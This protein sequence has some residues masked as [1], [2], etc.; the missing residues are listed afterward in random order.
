MGLM[1]V[2]LVGGLEGGDDGEI[3]GWVWRRR[4]RRD[5]LSSS[6]SLLALSLC[7]RVCAWAL[8]HS[9]SSG[10]FS[11]NALKVKSKHKWFYASKWLFTG[12]S[13]FDFPL[14]VFSIAAKRTQGCKMISWKC[15]QVKQ[16]QPTSFFM[17]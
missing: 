10:V 11:G 3:S 7:L 6:L 5:Q 16:T 4:R 13:V 2:R 12:Q 8:S 17:N 15:F 14:T 1:A 9:L